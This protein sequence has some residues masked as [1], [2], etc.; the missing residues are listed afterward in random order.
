MELLDELW[1]NDH[2]LDQRLCVHCVLNN[3][4]CGGELLGFDQMLEG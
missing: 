4:E 3:A 1:W 2:K